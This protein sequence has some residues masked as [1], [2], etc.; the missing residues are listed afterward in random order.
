M[1]TLTTASSGLVGISSKD[2]AACTRVL[3]RW[4][5]HLLP[6]VSTEE[7]LQLF[8][9][10]KSEESVLSTLL[11]IIN[12]E[13]AFVTT[14]GHRE[15]SVEILRG[16]LQRAFSQQ[17]CVEANS[18]NIL[19][20]LFQQCS[21]IFERRMGRHDSTD[22]QSF[23]GSSLSALEQSEHIRLSLVELMSELGNYLI[24]Y[25]QSVAMEPIDEA[26]SC[27]C[28][29]LAKYVLSDPF[30]DILVASCALVQTLAKLCPAAV[31]LNSKDLLLHLAGKD[32]KHCLFRNRRSKIRSVA[33]ET[34]CAIV[35]CQTSESRSKFVKHDDKSM[36]LH[37]LEALQSNLLSGW[38]DLVKMDASVSVR[39]ATLN[40]VGMTAR[41]FDW[42]YTPCEERHGLLTSGKNTHQSIELT[43][44]VES[45][46]LSLFVLG[47][48]DGNIQVQSLAIQRLIC[49]L[50]CGSHNTGQGGNVP[51]DVIARYFDPVLELTL[52]SCSL[53]WPTCQGRVRSLEALQV[54]LSF[55]IAIRDSAVVTEKTL[56]PRIQ[57]IVECLRKNIVSGEKDVLQAALAASSILGGSDTC[58]TRVLDMLTM[59]S[60][61]NVEL[62]KDAIVMISSPQE[63]A[64]T[65]LLLSRM[66]KGM[67]CNEDA[68]EIL[69]KV[70]P[71]FSVSTPNWIYT[72]PSS[73][74]TITRLISNTSVTNHVS[75][76]SSLAWALLDVI[77]EV[78]KCC[79]HHL[80]IG[81]EGHDCLWTL[82]E[83]SVLEILIGIVH[84]LGCPETYGL[85]A[86]AT[87][88]LQDFS[89]CFLCDD[90]KRSLLDFHFRKLLPKITAAAE[91]AFPWEESDAAFLAM[92]ALVRAAEGATVSSNFELVAPFFVHHMSSTEI[93][94]EEEPEEYSLRITLMSLLQCILSDNTF[95]SIQHVS[96]GKIAPTNIILSLVLPNLVWRAGGLASALRKLSVATVFSLLCHMKRVDE[97]SALHSDILAQLIPV[98]HSCL[99][100]TEPT[101][102]EIAAVCIAFILEQSSSEVIQT[103]W[104][105]DARILDTLQPS[106]LSLL[107]DNHNPTRIAACRALKSILT[108]RSPSEKALSSLIVH[109]DD[110]DQEVKEQVHGVLHAVLELLLLSNKYDETSD[111][112][113]KVL[114]TANRY[115]NDALQTHRDRSYC[116]SLI[117]MFEG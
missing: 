100:D 110:D 31:K 5:S 43:T 34:S 9:C 44:F 16:L 69:C 98:L 21:H 117:G 84:L 20:S 29:M 76:N 26:A 37:M 7:I 105:T 12:D 70:D 17:G 25:T 99:E 11:A 42:T 39:V 23:H 108:Q 80:S 106:L 15:S 2:S 95:H 60:K 38:E 48:S 97:A 71:T 33:V 28:Q 13:L 103:I 19:H 30:P 14:E 90:V 88:I 61:N 96:S 63:A 116:S 109:L 114:A 111:C 51:W 72:S 101:T 57:P 91:Y 67:I 73:M 81:E 112:S 52:A 86:Q 1:T 35:L 77:S 102:R 56:L 49:T 10:S 107:D 54:L 58:S 8:D 62:S 78:V 93:A 47:A 27:I 18:I 6:A 55:A 32:V 45:K 50:N 79:K 113:G 22:H 74:A 89:S 53:S 3:T 92:T 59:S 82:K 4:K 87:A 75:V 83:E 40:A 94:K 66:V 85:A 104:I 68:A 65:M 24:L 64:S 46:I 36:S 115:L 41:Q